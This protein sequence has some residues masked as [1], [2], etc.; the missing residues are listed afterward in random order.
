M[1]GPAMDAGSLPSGP[2][3]PPEQPGVDLSNPEAGCQD[4]NAFSEP[5]P[6]A[7]LR[8]FWYFGVGFTGLQRQRPGHGVIAVLDPGNTIPGFAFNADTGIPPPNTAPQLLNFAD[9]HPDFGWG[10]QATL[11]YQ[12]GQ[13]TFELTGYYLGL[14]TTARQ[15]SLPGQ[16]D[17]PFAAFNP[18]LGFTG[19]NFLW[20]QADFAEA[21][22]ATRVANAEF[23][24]RYRASACFETIVGVR[25]LDVQEH[26]SILTDD[27]GIILPTPD[28]FV[29][30]IYTINTHNR[31]VAPQLGFALEW[32][33]AQWLSLSFESKGAWGANFFSEDHLLLRG[34]GFVGPSSHLADT[35]F[36]Q[37]YDLALFANVNFGDCIRVRAGYQAL[38][39]VDVPV[40]YQQVD[41]DPN[42]A[43][44]RQ[45]N[46]GSIF[47]HGPSVEI[48]FAF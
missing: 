41:F 44:G 40:A 9:L 6:A 20:L 3:E 48:Q 25:Y 21:I 24:W 1:Q 26:F 39:V 30:A 31:I 43:N 47:F 23:N 16:V 45:N 19:N 33:L 17:L 32:P 7:P 18:P 22:Q 12:L 42:N 8:P 4:P 11:A 14:T 10:T 13:N 27:D 28:P 37:V 46:R 35:H 34:D 2:A 36:S 15:V 5:K 29:Q 38:W